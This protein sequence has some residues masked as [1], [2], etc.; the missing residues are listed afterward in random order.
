[1]PAGNAPLP[2][3]AADARRAG[4]LAGCPRLLCSPRAARRQGE[5]CRALRGAALA[6][7]ERVF[8]LR[9]RASRRRDGLRHGRR[10]QGGQRS[11]AGQHPGSP[12]AKAQVDR[13]TRGRR[14]RL[15][16]RAVRGPGDRRRGLRSECI[17]RVRPAVAGPSTPGIRKVLL[18]TTSPELASRHARGDR[19]AE[20]AAGAPGARRGR[21]RRLERDRGQTTSRPRSR[22]PTATRPST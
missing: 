10:A 2:S 20:G 15:S 18:L 16:G 19:P 6:G 14:A 7:V 12:R 9:R 5:C 8:K 21:P 11:T 22:S 13:A 1:V 3:T 4:Q 17:R